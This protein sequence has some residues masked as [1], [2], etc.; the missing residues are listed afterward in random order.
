MSDDKWPLPKFDAGDPKHAHAVGVIAGTF[1]QF[2]RSI[3][4]MFL[5]HPAQDHAI[6]YDALARDLFALSE[7]KRITAIRRF[8]S[9]SE[10]DQSVRSAASNVLD[11]FD[12]AH[13]SRNKIL[14]AE[15]YPMGF[16]ANPEIFYLTK[17]ANKSDPSSIY[18]ALDLTTLRSI[19]ES[20]REGI[21]RSAELNIHVRYRNADLSK[22]H[23]SLWVYATS[24]EFPTLAVPPSLKTT[25][26]PKY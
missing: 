18:M 8:Y 23:K 14:H 24:N 13:D 26:L 6:P 19:A 10:P 21:V 11:F 12:L 22:L 9:A 7:G 25:E 3:E 15:R 4:S 2:E 5:H 20:M 1:V 16:G 17:R